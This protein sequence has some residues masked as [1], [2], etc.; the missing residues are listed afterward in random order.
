MLLQLTSFK[1]PFVVHTTQTPVEVPCPPERDPSVHSSTS[2]SSVQYPQPMKSHTLPSQ[3]AC[4]SAALPLCGADGLTPAKLRPL[5]F[6]RQESC[7]SL[8]TRRREEKPLTGSHALT[9]VCIP[10]V[11]QRKLQEIFIPFRLLE[12]T[13]PTLYGCNEDS[14]THCSQLKFCENRES[15][16]PFLLYRPGSYRKTKMRAEFF[17]HKAFTDTEEKPLDKQEHHH[18]HTVSVSSQLH[19]WV[20]VAL[21][22]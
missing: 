15:N 8:S 14:I 18:S 16:I 3:M 5:E 12:I 4:F 11:C 17:I 21:P 9:Y 22:Q 6:L 2:R 7:K 19:S 1:I 13:V 10:D 20:R